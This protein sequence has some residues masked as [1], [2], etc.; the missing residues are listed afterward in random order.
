MR[1]IDLDGNEI[2]LEGDDLLARM[3]QHEID[4]LDGVLLLDRLE[5]DVR[6]RGAARAAHPRARPAT[7][8]RAATVG[9]LAADAR[10]ACASSSSARPPT[11]CPPLARAARGRARRR[12][13]RHPTRPPRGAGAA[14]MPSPVKAAAAELGLP[15]RTPERAREVVDEVARDAAPSSAWSSRSGSCFAESLARRGAARLREP[16][17]LAAAALAGRGAGRAGDPRR[18]RRDRRVHHGDRG[19]PRHRPVFA[20]VRDADRADETAGELRDAARRLGTDLLVDTLPTHPDD[21]RPSRRRASPPTPT[22]SRSTSSGSTGA[23]PAAELERLS[24]PEPAARRVDRRRRQR[25][26]RCGARDRAGRID[27]EPGA[28][29]DAG[30]SRPATAARLDEVQPEGSRAMDATRGW[31][32]V[33]G[34]PRARA[35]SAVDDAARVGRARRAASASRTART[36]T[37]CC[38]RCCARPTLDDRDRAVR[39]RPRLRHACARNARSTICSGRVLDAAASQRLDPPV[40]AALR[41]GAYQ[42]LHGVPRARGGGRRPSTQSRRARRARGVRQRRP[43]RAARRPPWPWPEGDDASDRRPHVVPRLARRACSSRELG[44]DDA[45]AALVADERAAPR[46]RCGVNPRRRTRRRARR[47]AAA[48]GRRGRARAASCPTRCSCAASAIPARSPRCATGAPPRRTRRSQAVVAVARPATGRA[49]SLDVAAAPGGKATAHRRAR[50]RRRLGRRRS[51]STPG[52]C[53]LIDGAAAPARPRRRRARSSPTA[54]TP[55]SRRQSFDRVLLDAPCSGLGVLRRR[56]DAALAP[57]ARGDRRARRA[58]ARAARGGRPRRC[59]PAARS[60]TRCARSPRRRPSASTSGR[61][62]H[63]PGFAA[64]A[65]P[66][67]PWRRT[68]AARSCSRTPPAPTACSSSPS[69]ALAARRASGR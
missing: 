33:R 52:G 55:P 20:R 50:G 66:G 22:S 37:S 35:S 45:R 16:A 64:L 68:A 27:A 31:P 12:A 49:R 63:L 1:G 18:R 61:A 40:R 47:R 13:R 2:V 48:R 15:V 21:A 8:P 5:P 56:P 69:A 24:A 43:A 7:I 29:S 34:D 28:C 36:R 51:T 54:A 9:L 62:A 39:H 11:R 67:A 38:P 4:H 53:A 26:S 17:L 32:A 60:C 57:A 10:R 42:L 14:P 3:I 58:A 46:S 6:Q 25:G 65:P 41:L 23:R 19:G 30:A 44:A 59:G